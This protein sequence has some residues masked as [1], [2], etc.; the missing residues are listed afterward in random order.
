MLVIDL[1]YARMEGRHYAPRTLESYRRLT[2]LISASPLAV[3]PVDAPEAAQEAQRLLDAH[4][5]AGHGRTAEQLYVW[6]RTCCPG[7]MAAIRRPRY[8]RRDPVF[9]SL[10]EARRLLDAAEDPTLWLAIALALSLGLRRGELC[11]LRWADIDMIHGILHIQQQRQRVQGRGLVSGPPKSASGVRS[12]PIPPHL[13]EV[14]SERYLLASADGL[15]GGYQPVYVLDG[16]Q[17]RGISPERLS[18]AFQA[19]TARAGVRCTLHGL[20]HTMASLAAC[21]GVAMPVLQSILG[22][23]TISTTARYYTH[24]YQSAKADALGVVASL[25]SPKIT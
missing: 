22:H 21:H 6:L 23:A 5:M 18:R 12:M 9:I 20:R 2:A 24:V 8:A 3:L 19:L 7:V 11:G 15:L 13:V 16:P 25:L 4:L 1:L 10:D 14:L 17:H